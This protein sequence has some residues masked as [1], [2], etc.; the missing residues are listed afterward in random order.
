M[1]DEELIAALRDGDELF[2]R[3]AAADRLEALTA[4][5]AQSVTDAQVERVSRKVMAELF[6]AELEGDAESEWHRVAEIVRAALEAAQL[7][8]R[9]VVKPDTNALVIAARE[10][11]YDFAVQ[12]AMGKERSEALDKA[13]EPFAGQV[14]WDDESAALDL[15]SEGEAAKQARV[16]HFETPT[17]KELYDEAVKDVYRKPDAPQPAKPDLEVVGTDRDDREL[18]DFNTAQA[19]I[20]ALTAKVGAERSKYEKAVET[21]NEYMIKFGQEGIRAETAEARVA[22]LE[23]ALES[24]AKTVTHTTFGTFPSKASEIARAL[25]EAHQQG[26]EGAAVT[27]AHN[28]GRD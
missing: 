8:A 23:E 27:V 6:E 11:A 28:P 12:E 21:V 18:C 9:P 19:R 5:R 10:I 4:S 1:T 13:L 2:T 20:A 7:P 16:E 3:I 22:Q 14:G 25:L 15:T 26:M 17:L 24:I